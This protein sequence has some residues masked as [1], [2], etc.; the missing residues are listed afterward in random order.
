MKIFFL[1]DHFERY[2]QCGLKLLDYHPLANFL[3][4]A[5]KYG[6]LTNVFFYAG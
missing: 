5:Q 4:L 2:E 3:F 1:T 6:I